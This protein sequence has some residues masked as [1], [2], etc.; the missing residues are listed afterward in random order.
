MLKDYF[1]SDMKTFFNTG[2]FA[3]THQ[4]DNVD[5]VVTID[6]DKIK[7]VSKATNQGI[8]LGEIL[9]SIP[10]DD[11]GDRIPHVGDSQVFDKKL[12]YITSVTE[13]MGVY[14]IILSQ[15]RGE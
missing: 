14:E 9:Y 2:E 4:I 12:M 3:K 5:K 7:E 8:S 11:Y 13:D 1:A 6:N 10:V 15:N